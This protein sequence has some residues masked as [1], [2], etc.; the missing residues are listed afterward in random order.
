MVSDT[1]LVYLPWSR[2]FAERVY[3]LLVKHAG[4]VDSDTE[5]DLFVLAQTGKHCTEWRFI[6][7]LGF[8]GKFWRN[9]GHIYVNCYVE[10]TTPDRQL[11]INHTNTAL[12]ALLEEEEQ[13][14]R[15]SRSA[16]EDQKS[17]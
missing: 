13:R 9:A 7:K 16:K 14:L 3:D 8:G 5:R 12:W 4:A 2:S 10:D 15:E 6:G 11:I 1:S 17:G